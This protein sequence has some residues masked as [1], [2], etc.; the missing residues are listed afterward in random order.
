MKNALRK[1][2][3]EGLHPFLEG[4]SIESFFKELEKVPNFEESLEKLITADPLWLKETKEHGVYFFVYKV[5]CSKEE[6]IGDN[7]INLCHY[8]L[9]LHP[10]IKVT[11]FRK[12]KNLKKR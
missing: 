8:S 4:S 9:G 2:F 1:Y 6:E 10:T 11:T 12:R 3:P 7:M 5:Y